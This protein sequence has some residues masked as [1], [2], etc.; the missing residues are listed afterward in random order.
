MTSIKNKNKIY[1]KFCQAKDQTRKQYLH[2]KFK[3]YTKSL[4]NLT[5]QSKQYSAESVEYKVSKGMKEI[6]LINKSNEMQS[7]CLKIGDYKN[8]SQ[9]KVNNFFGTIAEKVDKKT[10]NPNKQ[11]SSYLK[12]QD[13]SS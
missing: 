11:F 12:N 7:F 13:L 2:E 10:P 3:I 1:N 9:E 5:R 4:A 6:I 8:K